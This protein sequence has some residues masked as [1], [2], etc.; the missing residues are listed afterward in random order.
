MRSLPAGCLFALLLGAAAYTADSP[1]Q[2]L[3]NRLRDNVRNDMQRAPRYTCVQT[4][5]RTQSHPQ[6]ASKAG[7]KIS[8]CAAL[9]A[10]RK[11][12]N[13]GGLLLWHDRLR[14]DVAVGENSEM[15]SW[16]GARQFESNS[17]EGLT[18]SGPTGSGDFSAF[19]SSVFGSDAEGFR[20]TGEE[21]TSLGKL[22]GFSFVV[23]LGKSHYSYRNN[24]G[25]SRIVAYAG[26]FWAV[27][28]TAQLKRLMIEASQ[29]PTD[30]VCQVVDTM[31]Y[32]RVKIGAGEFLLPE[33][34]RMTVL[35][36][37]GDE[38]V[39]ETKY[40]KCHEFTG[41]ST[42]RF[43]DPDEP[44]SAA[45]VAKEALKSLP[46]KTHIRVKIDPPVNSETAA[47]GD[48]ITGVVEREVKEKGKVIIRTTD[49][50]HGRLLRLEQMMVPTPRWTVA[51]RFDS[52]ERDGV[53]QPIVLKPVD[54]GDRSGGGSEVRMVGRRMQ[55]MPAP[56]KTPQERPAGGGVFTFSEVG[57]L[58]LDAKF[59]SE[60]E[61]K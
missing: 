33:V 27:P 4:V 20:Y 12:T 3:F 18:V 49:R 51:I 2:L 61:T 36:P 10:A 39:N 32:S 60:W 38:T 5:T 19:L 8:G 47:A 21:T 42:I 50:L 22:A 41:E 48:P 37:T 31:D 55:S 14:L 25:T 52:I 58:L 56:A 17:L 45:N 28:A 40:S 35:Y 26:S 11:Q 15:F 34:A 44:N 53:E 9:V 57:R 23:P 24:R 46:P 59:H 54:D 16:A 29:F 30:D 43:D 7:G 1:A 13:G 6:Y